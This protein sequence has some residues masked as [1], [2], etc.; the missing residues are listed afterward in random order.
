MTDV[1]FEP[2]A[3]AAMS[4]LEADPSRDRLLERVDAALELL[5]TSPGDARCRRRSYSPLEQMWGI[6][7][8]SG[9]DDWLIIWKHGPGR[10]E[11][12]VRY[13]GPDL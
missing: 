4:A 2:N 11:V 1:L 13:V 7:V 8:R 5:A 12:T 6:P 10:D 9:D 3:D